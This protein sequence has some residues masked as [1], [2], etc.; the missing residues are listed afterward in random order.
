MILSV[1]LLGLLLHLYAVW[2]L[3]LDYLAKD[4]ASWLW[5]GT[6][7]TGADR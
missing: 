3:S 6:L 7:T 1:V 2:K 4:A 5:F